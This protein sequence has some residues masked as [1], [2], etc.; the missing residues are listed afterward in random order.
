M[1]RGAAR[2]AR[3]LDT[4]LSECGQALGHTG[5]EDVAPGG[6]KRALRSTRWRYRG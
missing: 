1:V 4:L 3:E 6:F 5:N 2:A